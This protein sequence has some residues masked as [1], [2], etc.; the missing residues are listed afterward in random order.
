MG[1]PRDPSHRTARGVI[2]STLTTILG[3]ACLFTVTDGGQRLEELSAREWAILAGACNAHAL[4]APGRELTVHV[5]HPD[6]QHFPRTTDD[7]SFDGR[8][9]LYR[10]RRLTLRIR[11]D[12][13]VSPA[14]VP[15]SRQR[16]LLEGDTRH[17]LLSDDATAVEKPLLVQPGDLRGRILRSARGRAP[18]WYDEL[19]DLEALRHRWSIT[20]PRRRRVYTDDFAPGGDHEEDTVVPAGPVAPGAPRAVLV[21]MHWFEIGGAERWAFETVRLVR[22]A[23][24]LPVVL[25]S[26]DSHHEWITRPELEGAVLLPL[27][28]PTALTQTPGGEQLLRAVLETFDVRGVVV[29]HSQWLYD[30]LP[31]VKLSRPDVPTVDSTHIVEYRGGGFPVSAVLADHSIDLHHVIS[32]SLAAWM[33]DT[34]RVPAEKVV[35]APLGGLTVEAADQAFR[36]R[37]D[38]RP[39][40]VAFVGRLARQKAPEVFVAAAARA[41]SRGSDVRFILHGHGEL[42]PWVDDLVDRAGLQDVLERRSGD[43]PVVRTLEDSDLLAV[44]SHNE[45]L[46]LTTLEAVAHGVPVIS[47]DVGAQSDLV[48]REALVPRNVHRAVPALARLIG[49]LADDEAARRLLWETERTA[50]RRLLTHTSANDWFREVVSTW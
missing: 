12:L 2:I 41:R 20:R 5:Y 7:R 14:P 22:E 50:E 43:V 33:V 3:Q 11:N 44:T 47:T 28:E 21:G 23:G 13:Q 26:R 34:Q 35:M 25:T 38:G 10:R 24:L 32:P 6:G 49:E 42:A 31:F 16:V 39:F 9:R 17:V 48:P 19:R 8:S 30:R 15:D 18:L 27:S 45:G 1:P 36:P 29:H 37:P 4:M 46:T 40:T